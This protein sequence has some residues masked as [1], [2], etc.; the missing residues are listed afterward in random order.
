MSDVLFF[1]TADL[2][3]DDAAILR[4][5]GLPAGAEPSLRI[6]RGLEEALARFRGLAAPRGLRLTIDPP[7]FA[8]AYHGA[9]RNQA[10]TPLDEIVPRAERLALFAATVGEPVCREVR[11]L[12]AAGELALGFALDAVAAEAT[13][14]LADRMAESFRATLAKGEDDDLRVLPYSPGYC[15]WHVS[16]QRALFDRLHPET[17]GI[18]LSPGCMMSP[19]KSV[20]GVLVA[21]PREAHLFRR[22]FPFCEDCQTHACLSRMRAAWHGVCG[23]AE[24]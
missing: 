22:E 10:V 14:R 18:T 24:V 7:A 4:R 1:A 19:V 21:G 20:S 6:R 11:E 12:F 15:G 5:Q 16:G 17:I 8:E 2:I 3:A 13:D 9:G 23:V